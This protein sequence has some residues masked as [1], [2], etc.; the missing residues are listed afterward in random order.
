MSC[1]R[2]VVLISALALIGAG[3]YVA[4]PAAAALLSPTLESVTPS[5]IVPGINNQTVTLHGDFTSG[6]SEVTFTPDTGITIVGT[7]TTSEDQTTITLKVNVA[8]DAPN[9]ARDV[10]VTGGVLGSSST[11]SKCVTVGPDITAVSGPLANSSESATFTITGHA[12]KAPVT[13][14]ISRSGYGFNAAESDTILATNVQVPNTT[15]IIATVN[16]F[17][18]APGRWK[19]AITQ[20]NG[21]KASFGDG[22]TTGMQITGSK[23]TLASISPSRINSSANNA[24]FALTGAGFAQGMT[25]TVS[26]SGV[27]QSDRIVLGT[28]GGKPDPTK[29]TLKLTSTASPSNGPQTLVLKNADAQSSTNADA[30]CVNCDLPAPGAP[31][32][33][34]VSPAIVGQGASLMQMIV[35][36]TNFAGPVP[37]V[38]VSPNGT[39]TEA[40]D[41]TVTRDSSTQL[42]LN[43]SVGTTAPAGPRDLTITN[44]NGGGTTT[45]NDA[46][47]VS[48]DFNVTHLT[49][50][51]RPQGYT[52]TVMINGSGFSGAPTV[53]F[54]PDSGI[55]VTSVT[56]DSAAKITVGITVAGNAAT[57]PRDVTVTVGGVPKTCAGCFTVG[58]V[59]TVT[60]IAPNAA[61]GGAPASISSL[62][63]TNFAPGAGAT[64][65]RAGQP[66]IAMTDVVVESASKISGTF[67]L[68]NAAPGK[69]S[70]RV[71]N[72]D[73]G[74]AVFADAFEVTLAPPTV[75]SV[76]P[77]SIT[78]GTTAT[79]KLVGTSF[80]PGVIVSFPNADGLT[81]AETTRKSN[82]ETEIKVTAAEGARLGSRD[83]KATNTDGQSDSCESCLVVVQGTQAKLFGPGVTAYENFNGG[84]FVGAGNIDGVPSNGT[85]FVTAPNAGGGPHLRPYRVNPA[86]GNIS[87][88]GNGFMA[89][90]PAFT[91]GVRVAVG[92][93]DG[94]PNNGEEIITAA[95]PGGGPH[96]RIF[97][98]N[99]DLS[100]SEPFG[101]GFFA[102]GP[103]FHGG[104]WVAALD[105][106][107]DGKDEI[108]TGAGAGGGPHVRVFKLDA[109]GQ[110]FS[111]L[112]GWMAYDPAFGGGVSVGGGNLVAEG[113]DKPILQEVA[114]APS[115]GGG[116]HV[117]IFGG[118]GQVKREFMAFSSEDS[119]G[120]RVTVGDFNFDTIDDIAVGRGTGTD[121]FIAQ[122]TDAPKSAEPLAS[123]NPRPL[124]DA[125]TVGTNIAATDVDLDGDE[126]IVVSPDHDS[127]VTIRL[128]RPVAS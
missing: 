46:F 7:P 69:W 76:E 117:R 103:E 108:V 79:L 73:G 84:A 113:V 16:P 32:I 14:Q 89:Y 57:G 75:S 120:Y 12:F 99:N 11:C 78:Q 45:A 36:G 18:R 20:D 91:G 86:N 93:I 100:V 68:A 42:T 29:A 105:V 97:R 37:T 90:S 123:P 26:G 60:S 30:I 115:V 44:P 64:L 2:F 51:G 114:T 23:P 87:E 70:V 4:R 21:G 19:V 119:R 102:Y 55:N 112:A 56:R 27:T 85:E 104:V 58:L 39:G 124:G 22:I 80:A 71:T 95:G 33:T 128:L 43:V 109:N 121:I 17:A 38:T 9:T 35:R 47:S 59:P 77:E 40:I 53:S 65:E 88:L 25:A 110:T 50:A 63:G 3:V 24:T 52:G 28:I 81:V 41:I 8:P 10:T 13:V 83:V 94:N 111:E 5:Q 122:I 82:T 6:D 62:N 107:G 72:V 49:P 34:S 106:N 127:A 125:L 96:V 126:D 118:T 31:T 15:T 98:L 54:N 92:N 48:T 66:S 67:D 116:P 1:R 74:T 61:T 101:T